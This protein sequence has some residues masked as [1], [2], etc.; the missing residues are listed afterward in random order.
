M[1]QL[2][3]VI[4]D[5][6]GVLT[7]TAEYHYL[8]WQR[9]AEEEGLSFS[10]DVNE[11][12][13]GVSRRDSLLL[14]LDGKTVAEDELQGMMARK[15]DYYRQ[16][17]E[18]VSPADL[19]PGVSVLLDALDAAGLPYALASA[20]KNAPD[21]VARL[22]I[23]ERL[24]V[25]ADGNSVSRQK[26]APDLFRYAAARLRLP[27]ADCLVVEDAEAGVAAAVAAGMPVLALGPAE[28]FAALL[29]HHG[30]VMLR[31]DLADVTVA[32]LETMVEEDEEWVVVQNEFQAQTQRHMETVFTTGNGYFS[33]RGSLEEGYPD[34]HLLTLAHGIFDDMPV[35]FTELV[36]L[37]NWLDVE[38]RVN[39][40]LFRLDQGQLLSFRRTL[41]M[42][43]GILRRDARWQAPGGTI[44]DLSFERFISYTDQHTAGLRLLVTAVNRP[45]DL[46]IFY[47]HKQPR[48]QWGFAPLETARP[49]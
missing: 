42:Y 33:T 41:N 30:R 7:D 10:R 3:A 48:R 13:R 39:G 49:R 8:A 11:K 44:L 46:E 20:S 4:F 19:L 32:D 35:S 47:R 45:C 6:D 37:P 25:I 18:K 24:T 31:S 29:G 27:P 12:L 43:E 21:V 17:L 34:D 36:N 1:S 15:N 22:G 38:L 28:R 23:A 40:Q 14:I 9:L 26:P 2:K 16:L 5:L